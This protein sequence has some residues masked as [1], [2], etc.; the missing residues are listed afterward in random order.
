MNILE[1]VKNRRSIRNFQKKDIPED[2]IDKLTESLIWAPSAGNLQSRKF[3]FIRDEAV[4][5]KIAEAALNQGFIAQA[6]LVIVGCTDSHVAGKYGE[7][8]VTLYSIQDVACS[9]MAMMLVA[10][11]NKLGTCWVGAF[12][13]NEL[14]RILNL[15]M[16]LK[17]VV[18]IPVGYPSKNPSPPQRVSREEAVEFI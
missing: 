14:T 17:P 1:A 15:P 16:N 10:F 6:P 2:L 9:I 5:I 13:E 11:D 8:G 3:Y 12:R 4:K 7:R 18:I